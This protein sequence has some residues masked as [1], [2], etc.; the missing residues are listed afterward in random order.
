MRNIQGLI[1]LQ[2]VGS[3]GVKF[4]AERRRDDARAFEIDVTKT[5]KEK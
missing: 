5:K 4:D 2:L 1:I 3:G